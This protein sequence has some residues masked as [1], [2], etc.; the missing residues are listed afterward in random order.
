MI[1]IL[2]LLRSPNAIERKKMEEEIDPV[3]LNKLKEEEAI[4]IMNGKRKTLAR[5]ERQKITG[6]DVFLLEDFEVD[7]TRIMKSTVKESEEEKEDA[8][9]KKLML[10]FLK[11]R[12]KQAVTDNQKS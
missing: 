11:K 2:K 6:G 8:K 1:D 7:M 12:S 5:K 10:S 9:N 3:E 4:K